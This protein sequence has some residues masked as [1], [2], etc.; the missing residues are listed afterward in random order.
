MNVLKKMSKIE[1]LQLVY[2]S[3]LMKERGEVINFDFESR[4]LRVLNLRKDF[5]GK[6][7]SN[8]GGVY[9]FH[10][11]KELIQELRDIAYHA[12][13]K[14]SF[15]LALYCEDTEQ[16]CI[17]TFPEFDGMVVEAGRAGAVNL[18]ISV[19]ARTF[20]VRVAGENGQGAVEKRISKKNSTCKLFA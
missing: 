16:P 9:C 14:D 7:A 8:D 11:T 6:Y 10:F 3:S 4:L 1:Q 19:T 18:F 12:K 20:N 15:C 5:F 2:F 17:L 13:K